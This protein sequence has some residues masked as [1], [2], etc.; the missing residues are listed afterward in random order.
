MPRLCPQ[1]APPRRDPPNA[2]AQGW[3]KGDTD[4]CGG[5]EEAPGPAS[6]VREA[7]VQ[8]VTAGQP[9]TSGVGAASA[10]ALGCESMP[11]ESL[12]RGEMWEV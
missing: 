8:T 3:G 11:G 12:G 6:P 7:S 4:D 2:R 10:K 9:G 5:S 1:E